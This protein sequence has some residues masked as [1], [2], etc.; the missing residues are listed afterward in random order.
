MPAVTQ[1]RS[2]KM[3]DEPSEGRP[4]APVAGAPASETGMT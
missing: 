3:V 1:E 4:G 2:D